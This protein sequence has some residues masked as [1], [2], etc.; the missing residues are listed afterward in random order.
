MGFKVDYR[1]HNEDAL[2]TYLSSIVSDAEKTEKEMLQEASVKVK[3]LVVASLNKHKRTL[4]ARYK[5]RPAMAD[6]VKINKS[7]GIAKIQGGKMTG[8]LWHLVNDGNLHSTPT[9]FMDEALSRLDGSI[10]K[11]WDEVVK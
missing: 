4:A 3:E 11:V 1:E 8:T 6:D 5:G 2:E 9:H 7:K 10:D